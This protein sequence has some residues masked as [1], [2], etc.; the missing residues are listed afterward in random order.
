M[1]QI[2]AIAL[3]IS[4]L[5]SLG[6]KVIALFTEAKKKGWIKDGNALREKIQIAKTDDERMA[7]ARALFEHESK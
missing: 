2:A 1:G 7:L 6:A 3:A 5:I 4:D